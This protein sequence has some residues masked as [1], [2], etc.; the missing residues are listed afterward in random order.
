MAT[1]EAPMDGWRPPGEPPGE[2]PEGSAG[3]PRRRR[4]WWIAGGV[5]LALPLLGYATLS[6]LLDGESLRQRVESAVTAATGRRLTLS[7]PVGL[8]LALVPTVVLEGPR[9]ANAPGGSQP[10]MFTARRVE[11]EVALLPLLSQRLEVRHLTVVEPQLLLETDASGQPNWRF[12]AA[13]PAQ[14]AQPTAPEASPAA[15]GVP[16]GGHAARGYVVELRQVELRGGRAVWHD[17]R[18]GLTEQ[19]DLPRLAL[20]TDG[21]GTLRMAGD[22]GFQ[23]L[24]LSLD[25]RGGTLSGLRSALSGRAPAPAAGQPVTGWPIDAS[26]SGEGIQAQLSGNFSGSL[27]SGRLRVS[28]DS[29]ARLAM[30]VP[31]LRLPPAEDLALDMDLAPGGPSAI[32]LAAGKVDLPQRDTGPDLSLGPVTV[33]APD[34]DGRVAAT[35]EAQI[36][37]LPLSWKADLPPPRAVQSGRGPWPLQVWVTGEDLALSLG[38]TLAG[39]GIEGAALDLSLKTQDLRTLGQRARLPLPGLRGLEASTH[40]V[41][42][43]EGWIGLRSLALRAEQAEAAGGLRLR[44]GAVPALDGQIDIARL[45]LD[46]IPPPLPPAPAP[47]ADQ[48]AGQAQDSG[49][50]TPA[51]PA[52]PAPPALP[53]GSRKV[54]PDLPVPLERLAA[55]EADLRI[56]LGLL[57]AARLDWRNGEMVLAVHGGRLLAEPLAVDGPG[58]RI[59]LRVAADG[60]A[61]PPGLDVSVRAPSLDLSALVPALLPSM[62]RAGGQPGSQPGGASGMLDAETALST[63]GRTL[64]EMAAGLNGSLGLA[65]ADGRVDISLLDAVA[66]DLRRLLL[67]NA[68]RNGSE[69]LRC[70]A[71]RLQARDGV[72]HAQAM[73][74]ET[75][76]A[77]VLGSGSVDLRQERLDLRLL[78]RARIGGVGLAIPVVV[79]GALAQPRLRADPQGAAS[80]GAAILSELSSHRGDAGGDSAGEAGKALGQALGQILGQTLGEGDEA[81]CAAQ[82]RIA[83]DGREGPV[84]APPAQENRSGGV[85]DLLRGLLRR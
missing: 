39:P 37:D 76:I 52:S 36:G 40:L 3:K 82:L 71:L 73:L 10:E 43:A 17:M 57:R 59:A 69:A 55:L 53:A 72:V 74:L 30:L 64:R 5:V 83:R 50:A 9:F 79:D 63:R 19:L 66:G 61:S 11:A 7:G 13:G 38:G 70:L 16:G 12:H 45:D 15:G 24:A 34:L 48:A 75:D 31:G 18:S 65:L 47:N 46:A 77:S 8:K 14:A 35:G 44:P 49:G 67:P 33:T 25:A 60:A 80:A 41:G 4:G 68:P 26:L 84:P 1:P 54:I 23:G 2:S 81:G 28:A 21:D 22:I 78:P 51:A 62:G 6:V 32:R 56:R 58:G 42:E 85:G 29:S 27:W 20:R